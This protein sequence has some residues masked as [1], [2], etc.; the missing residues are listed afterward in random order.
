M[1]F[2]FFPHTQQHLLF[3]VFLMIAILT[4][5]R[6]FLIVVLSCISLMNRDIEHLFIYLLVICR[7]SLEKCL[8]RSTAHFLIGLFVFWMLSYM[9]SLYIL[10]TNSLSDISFAN[11][12]Y[13]SVGCLFILLMVSLPTQKLFSFIRSHLFIFV[14]LSISLG[15]GSKRILL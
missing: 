2:S 13:H 10:D 6:W 3:V 12:F 8:F 15:G 7:S 1:K 4:G 14:F 5:G 9:S 11:I